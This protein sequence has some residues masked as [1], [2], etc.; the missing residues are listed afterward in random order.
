[1]AFAIAFFLVNCWIFISD[2]NSI[3]ERLV[4]NFNTVYGLLIIVEECSV[5]RFFLIHFYPVE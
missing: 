3:T 4:V 2:F 1:M 5:S